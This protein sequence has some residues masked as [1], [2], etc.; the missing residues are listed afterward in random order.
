MDFKIPKSLKLEHEELHRELQKA[1]KAGGKTAEAAKRVAELLHPHFV[2]EEEF[3]LPPL[4]VL[5]AVADGNI[6]PEMKEVVPLTEK[7]KAELPQMLEEHKAIVGALKK[8]AAAAKKE[9]KTRFVE[10]AEKLML[11][12]KTEE[13]FFYPTSVLI[14]EFLR[15][16]S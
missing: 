8:L 3:A 11:H 10:L 15:G 14:G 16:T 6:T 5:S 4:G 7:L 9:K 2:K 1:T 13:E 12:A